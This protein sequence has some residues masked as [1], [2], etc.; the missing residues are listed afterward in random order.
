MSPG[1]RLSSDSAYP[2][3]SACSILEASPRY[4]YPLT[5][6]TLSAQSQNLNNDAATQDKHERFNNEKMRNMM[7]RVTLTPPGRLKPDVTT[8]STRTISPSTKT[9][10]AS[11][12]KK[13]TMAPKPVIKLVKIHHALA[14]NYPSVNGINSH[15]FDLSPKNWKL[16][17]EEAQELFKQMS[18]ECKVFRAAVEDQAPYIGDNA[19]DTGKYYENIAITLRDI[20]MNK[21][22]WI[23]PTRDQ[24][25]GA[26]ALDWV[27]KRQEDLSKCGIPRDRPDS[28]FGRSG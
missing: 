23:E 14:V 3:P 17:D 22:W 26:K 15:R 20:M 19:R 27:K 18:D 5:P 7:D 2:N 10:I 8:P 28:L 24:R 4:S 21:C 6:P 13:K 9:P 16:F 12:K 1:L 11:S 25:K